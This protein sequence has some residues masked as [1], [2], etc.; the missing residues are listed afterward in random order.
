MCALKI[1]RFLPCGCSCLNNTGNK[2]PFRI[3]WRWISQDF[4]VV[5]LR[6]VFNSCNSRVWGEANTHAAFV[7]C[8]QKCFSVSVL[9][10]IVRVSLIGSY[11]LPLRLSAQI[12]WVF[13]EEMLPELLEDIPLA[14]RRNTWFQHDGFACHWAR[15]V[16]EHLTANYEMDWTGRVC[17]LAFQVTGSHTIWFLPTGLH[18]NF[19]LLTVRRFW[20]GSSTNQAQTWYFLGHAPINAASISALNWGRWTYLCISALNL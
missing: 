3:D 6:G 1:S 20:R 2:S 9:T 10:T 19:D 4:H 13:L 11:V 5:F 15:Q 14:L 18:E 17:G 7:H 8:H 16:P 12:Y